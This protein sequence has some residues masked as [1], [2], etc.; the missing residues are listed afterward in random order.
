MTSLAI[1]KNGVPIRL[2]EERWAHIVEEHSELAGL[3][4]EVLET[5]QDPQWIRGGRE[6]ELIAG[7]ESEPGKW[8]V[9][10]YREASRED[11]FIITAFLTRRLASIER[12]PLVW[13]TPSNS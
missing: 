13:P 3:L 11:G 12:R 8:F 10:F 1:S 9:V 6:G 2:T 7:R 4:F 5:V